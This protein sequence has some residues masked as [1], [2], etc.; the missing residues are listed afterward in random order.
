[1]TDRLVVALAILTGVAFVAALIR[2]FCAHRLAAI[3]RR[4]SVP[5]SGANGSRLILFT[6]PHCDACE[7]QKAIIE[8]LEASRGQ[9]LAVT[10]VDAAAEPELSRRFGVLIVPTIV[11]ARADGSI[12]AIT[13]G[14]LKQDRL[15]A[16]LA[17]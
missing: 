7:R 5:V 13:S 16:Q 11:V 17:S 14:L 9:P 2:A 8:R 4:E 6:G 15:E 10:V 12:A 1:M 3:A